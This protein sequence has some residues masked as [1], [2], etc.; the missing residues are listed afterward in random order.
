MQRLETFLAKKE[1]EKENERKRIAAKFGD[2]GNVIGEDG[3][4]VC[5]DKGIVLD[6]KTGLMW[7]T[8]DNGKLINW[9]DAKG[10]CEN[11]RGGGYTDWRMP[12][13]DELAG[14]YDKNKK[15]RHG[16]H[17]TKLIDITA[18]CPWASETRGSRAARFDFSDGTRRWNSQ[19]LSG[20]ARA[21][22]VRGGN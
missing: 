3:R 7:A 12:T 13:Q 19:S 11:Y 15:N 22:P 16:Y 1:A 4:F 17:V 8:K 14:L 5:G 20:T 21:L 10:Y 9:R 18:C 6:T 2:I